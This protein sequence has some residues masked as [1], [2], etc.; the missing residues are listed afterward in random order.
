MKDTTA[1]VTVC[2]LAAGLVAAPT[3]AARAGRF[4]YASG[5]ASGKVAALAIAPDATLHPVPGSPF[6]AGSGGLAI[7]VSPDGRH[8]YA[9]SLA[10]ADVSAFIV[11]AGGWLTPVP[12]SPF[13]AGAPA[14]AHA[15]SPDG[16]HLYV[17]TTADGG[18]IRG[19]AVGPDGS[20]SPLA[21]PPT[22]PPPPP[23]PPRPPPAGGEGPPP[24]LAMPPDGRHLYAASYLGKTITTYT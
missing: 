15:F 6:P 13:P 22:R 3:A 1:R 4:L 11:G 20:L 14:G 21:D 23:P 18:T 12:G 17:T 10:T 2:L 8:V 24:P 19:W 5:A 16:L 7:A 9:P